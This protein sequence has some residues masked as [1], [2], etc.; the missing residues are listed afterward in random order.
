MGLTEKEF[1]EI[2][3]KM[4]IPP[5]EHDFSSPREAKKTWDFNRWYREDNRKK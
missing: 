5:Y 4:A 1:N 2:V 3:K